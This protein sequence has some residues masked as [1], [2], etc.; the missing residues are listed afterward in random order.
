MLVLCNCKPPIH[1]GTKKKCLHSSK[2]IL[3]VFQSDLRS[4]SNNSLQ[5]FLQGCDV[6]NI[7]EKRQVTAVY[8]KKTLRVFVCP[9]MGGS[10][11]LWLL[12]RPDPFLSVAAHS[13]FPFAVHH[14]N[15]CFK[16]L[17]MTFCVSAFQTNPLIITCTLGINTRKIYI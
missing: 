9:M 12:M 17:Q 16:M 5:D 14:L 2:I 10:V 1:V 15:V 4:I 8:S 11:L 3:T 6:L 7:S 13:V